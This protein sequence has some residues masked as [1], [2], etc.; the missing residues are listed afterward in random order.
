MTTKIHPIISV[1]EISV[2]LNTNNRVEPELLE[3][4]FSLSAN[5]KNSE[6]TLET[7][8]SNCTFPGPQLEPCNSYERQYCQS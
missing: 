8:M 6:I 7:K 2:F 3:K 5:S 1:E 4:L